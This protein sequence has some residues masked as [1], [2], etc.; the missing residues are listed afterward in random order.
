[1]IDARARERINAEESVRE[2]EALVDVL[3]PLARKSAAAV[4]EAQQ[5]SLGLEEALAREADAPLTEA[6]WDDQEK[7]NLEREV[8][9]VYVSGHPLDQIRAQWAWTVDKG[10]G[11]L[12]D[13]DIT[14]KVSSASQ[15]LHVA[16]VVVEARPIRIRSGTM[17]KLTLE[18]LTGSREL[19]VWPDDAEGREELL[20][21]GQIISARVRVEEDTFASQRRSEEADGDEEGEG[22]E[23]EAANDAGKPIQLIAAGLFRWDPSVGVR[24]RPPQELIRALGMDP[25]EDPP[26]E[27]ARALAEAERKQEELY[28]RA[29]A[30]LERDRQRRGQHDGSQAARPAAGASA[31]AGGQPD[32]IV[33]KISAAQRHDREW[34][35][36]LGTI[37]KSHADENGKAVRLLV[38]EEN[39][40]IR[41]K[42]RVSV[43]DELR[44]EV[45]ALLR[46]QPAARRAT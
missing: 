43:S 5:E 15:L 41:L 29:Q 17:Y 39:K 21:V 22:P 38:R 11:Q 45:R 26:E 18:D 27:I 35:D 8:L 19:T 14:G 42:T 30:D 44:R 3:A 37:I 40:M 36:R 9:G 34:L 12:S 23:A 7:L 16:G 46:E 10:L 13:A 6:D 25:D 33:I 1:M 24:K 32:W 4:R 28:A 2:R 20:R 31:P